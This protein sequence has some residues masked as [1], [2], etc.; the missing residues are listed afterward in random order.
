MLPD[1]LVAEMRKILSAG[2][3]LTLGEIVDLAEVGAHGREVLTR[4]HQVAE[5]RELREPAAGAGHRP[6][7]GELAHLDRGAGLEL[8]DVRFP[9][10]RDVRR[11]AQRLAASAGRRLDESKP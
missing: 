5:A 7:V 6:E 9:C 8:T 11:L 1:P 10:E 4:E 2:K 3:K